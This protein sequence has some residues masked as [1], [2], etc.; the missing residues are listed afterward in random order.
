MIDMKE[1]LFKRDGLLEIINEKVD[2]KLISENNIDMYATVSKLIDPL[3]DIYV[4]VYMRLNEKSSQEIKDILLASSADII[5][6]W[7]PSAPIRRISLS[8]IS[9]LS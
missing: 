3:K 5:P 8:R 1:G 9:S 2:L 4:P 7:A 6:N